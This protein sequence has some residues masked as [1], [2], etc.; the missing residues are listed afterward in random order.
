LFGGLSL[1][2]GADDC[3]IE[4]APGR[5][6]GA[7][8]YTD[9]NGSIADP[10]KVRQRNAAV[11]PL[12]NFV[13]HASQRVDSDSHAQQECAMN[14]MVAW[15]KG[16]AL[17]ESP[18]DFNGQ[19]ERLEYAL[20]LEILAVKLK[21]RGFEI[22]P[23]KSWLGDL[24]HA[25]SKDFES[26]SRVG[27]LYVWSGAAAAAHAMLSRD[28]A[29]KKYADKVWAF[30]IQSIRSDGYISQELNRAGRATVYHLY[31]LSAIL[32]LNAF[33]AALGEE[34]KP[35][36]RAAILKLAEKIGNALCDPAEIEKASGHAQEKFAF[37]S[38]DFSHSFYG[39]AAFAN[40][41]LPDPILGKCGPKTAPNDSP[42]FGGD[43][44]KLR[45]IMVKQ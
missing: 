8:V 20:P 7:T 21:A 18:A 23:L 34:L 40:G 32:T 12:R 4:A 33:R 45:A 9:K 16:K 1:Q 41:V 2:A 37:A 17:L 31:N 24:A 19:R 26:L 42:L 10:E 22:D 3:Q 44:A 29:S 30:A 15:A 27:N 43:F 28:E 14:N 13:T 39:T 11:L 5:A 6:Q 25:V 35:T 38:G 36:E